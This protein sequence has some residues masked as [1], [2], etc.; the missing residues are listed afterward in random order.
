M[1]GKGCRHDPLVV[2]L[3]QGLVD[4]WVVQAAVDEIDK[5]VREEEEEGK[6]EKVVPG[7]WSLSGRVV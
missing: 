5:E 6:L 2:R 3:V 7:S 1:R 4:A